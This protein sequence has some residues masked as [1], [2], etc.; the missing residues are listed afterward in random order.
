MTNPELVDDILFA[1]EEDAITTSEENEARWKLLIVDDE[2]GVHT[3]TKLALDGFEFAGRGLEYISAHSGAE[4]RE[5]L[6]QHPDIAVVL[7]DVVMETDHAGLDVAKYVREELG[8]HFVRIVL[9]TGQPGQAPERTIITEFDINDYKE[10]TEL[11]AQKL[12]TLMYSS[13]RSYR[14]I[15][16]IESSKKGLEKVI[17]ASASIFELQS[18]EKFAYGVL[19]QLTS[20]LH[21][22]N[23]AVYCQGSSLAAER[24][25]N[26]CKI[27]AA[28][29]EFEKLVGCDARQVLD[30][31]ALSQV[32]EAFRSRR[33]TLNTDHY[34]GYFASKTGAENVL[35]MQGIRDLNDIDRHLVE[36]F[37]RNAAVAFEN[38]HLKEDIEDTQKEIVYRLGDAVET[39][40]NETGNHVK[41]VAEYSKLLALFSGMDEEEAEIV[42]LASP[43]HDVGK[44]GIPDAIL[45]KPGKLTEEE[46]EVMKTHTVLGHQLLNGSKRPVLYAGSTIALDHHEQWNGEG[47]PNGKKG[48]EINI[49]GRITAIAD[50]FDALGSARCY[51][52]AWE[53]DKIIGYLRAER[54]ARFDPALVDLFFTNM[55]GFLAI[56]QAYPDA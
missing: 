43:L 11:T 17:D 15:M 40:S 16:A 10:K 41:R 33:N 56:R 23:Q 20:L 49:Y 12:F 53:L 35:H 28:T 46:W 52:P 6:E 32:E 26:V 3:V 25:D 21:G 29:G 4:A 18:M 36:L 24:D 7:L 44:I 13:L 34:T 45:N 39:R 9:R 22:G 50:V 42:R 47:Y 55:P 48:D 5:L 37:C 1:D 30:P 27:L 19:E 31:N 38:V 51:K 14:D 2:P 54:G 8:N